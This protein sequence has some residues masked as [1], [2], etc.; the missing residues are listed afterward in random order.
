MVRDL[1]VMTQPYAD[2]QV[3][4]VSTIGQAYS[5]K[6]LTV[7]WTV[8]NLGIGITSTT[9][10]QDNVYLSTDVDGK[11]GII[12]LAKSVHLGA[13]G[14]ND[15]YSQQVTVEI[16]EGL[17]GTYYLQVQTGGVY[18]FMYV[19]MCVSEFFVQGKYQALA[20]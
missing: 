7:S 11:Q 9:S 17:S 1:D 5:G 4:S 13:L 18:E 19:H 2:L 12:P 16:P 8:A 10:W 20:W 14:V 15:R 3:E 6:A